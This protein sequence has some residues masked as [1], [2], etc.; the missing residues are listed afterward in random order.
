MKRRGWRV[1]LTVATIEFVLVACLVAFNWDTVRD[2]A[3]AWWFQ[4]ATETRTIEPDPA[5]RLR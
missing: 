1:A 3:E 4:L 2:H 5:S